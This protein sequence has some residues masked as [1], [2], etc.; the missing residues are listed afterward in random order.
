MHSFRFLTLCKLKIS[1]PP[2]EDK[3][4]IRFYYMEYKTRHEK[5]CREQLITEVCS[6]VRV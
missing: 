4:V 6:H 3:L 5:S 2:S 1:N